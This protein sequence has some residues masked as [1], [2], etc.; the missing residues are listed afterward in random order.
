[1]G[2]GCPCGHIQPIKGPNGLPWWAVPR[3][4]QRTCGIVRLS[5]EGGPGP[6]GRESVVLEMVPMLAQKS[7]VEIAAR[8]S[9]AG[10]RLSFF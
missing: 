2:M 3:S 8:R 4:I 10:Y 7:A 6:G 1:M 5:L 9:E